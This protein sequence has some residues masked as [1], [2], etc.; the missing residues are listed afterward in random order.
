MNDLGFL[1]GGLWLEGGA[2]ERQKWYFEL[3]NRLRR[4]MLK[5]NGRN[6]A[7]LKKKSLQLKE[8]LKDIL[9][10]FGEEI[11]VSTKFSIYE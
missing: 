7:S 2:I 9:E 5:K 1:F 10:N 4:Y 6:R 8:R 3:K 11:N